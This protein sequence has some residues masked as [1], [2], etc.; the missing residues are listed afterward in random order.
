MNPHKFEIKQLFEPGKFHIYLSGTMGLNYYRYRFRSFKFHPNIKLIDPA[1]E[2]DPIFQ[3]YPNIDVAKVDMQIV[4]KCQLVVCNINKYTAGTL[5]EFFH[6][7]HHNKLI[8]LIGQDEGINIDP[9][10]APFVT[11]H[12][13]EIQDC[14]EYIQ[15]IH[16]RKS[17]I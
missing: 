15:D 11:R 2:I 17:K 8:Y 10:I 12:F 7:F 13:F 1:V 6:A 5:G 9:W 4:E 16:G 3:Q 14:L